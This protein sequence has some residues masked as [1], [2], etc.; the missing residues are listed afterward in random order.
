MVMASEG[1]TLLGNE[2]IPAGLFRGPACSELSA[3]IFTNNCSISKFARVLVSGGASDSRHRYIRFGDI[4][5]RTAGTTRGIPFCLDVT[6]QEYRALWPQR[7][8]PWSADLEV[9][10]NPYTQ[11]PFPRSLL[12]EATHWHLQGDNVE[13][14]SFYETAILSSQTL[15][16]PIE[17]PVPTLAEARAIFAKRGL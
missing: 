5:D 11:H 10:H 17:K 3:V 14:E 7:Y 9:F 2:R 4:W 15:I 8:E 12:P 13:C 6:S 1:L 16:L